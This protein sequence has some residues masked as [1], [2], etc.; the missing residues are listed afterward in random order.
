METIIVDGS[1]L[2]NKIEEQ[3]KKDAKGCIIRPSVAAIEIGDNPLSEQY[4]KERED[5]CNRVG[6]YFRYYKFED[7]TPE[8]TIINKI[9]ELNNDDYVNGILV[10]LP[11]PEKYNE[12]R[13]LNTIINS[14]DIDGLTD[15]NVG[16]LIS[17]RKTIIPCTAL[18]IIELL[19]NYEIE[20]TDKNIVIIGNSK[21]VGRPLTNIFLNEGANVTICSPTS[22]NLKRY[23]K[24]ADILISSAD[25]KNLIS[26]DM[27]KDEVVVID[28][29][30]TVEDGIKYGDIDFKTVSKKASFITSDANTVKN[31]SIAMLLQNT[32]LCYNMKK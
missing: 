5:A 7:T 6:I 10:D 13:L 9:K 21:L 29:G 14:K 22:K 12:K 1:E 2:A 24:D 30:C 20:I 17:G 8:L 3:V 27:L 16:R 26:G 23:T 32:L 28:S 31:V 15:I 25:I 4:M 18:A 19:K 11:L